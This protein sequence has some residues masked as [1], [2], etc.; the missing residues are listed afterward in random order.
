[1]GSKAHQRGLW[2]AIDHPTGNV[3]AYVF[4]DHHDDVFLKLTALLEPFG[5]TRFYT[6]G[7]GA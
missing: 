6:D 2:H 5:S 4:G 3:L 1:V 7:W